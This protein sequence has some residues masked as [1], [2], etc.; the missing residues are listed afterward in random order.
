[1]KIIILL[2]LFKPVY[3]Q[4][5]L[6][7]LKLSYTNTRGFHSNFLYCESDVEANPTNILALF[8]TNLQDIISFNSYSIKGYLSL[9]CENSSSYMH[10]LIVFFQRGHPLAWEFPLATS[11]ES[12]LCF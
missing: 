2:K 9:V 4:F 10:C 8:E 3:L 11:D 7:S 5:S 1:M 12:D 6:S